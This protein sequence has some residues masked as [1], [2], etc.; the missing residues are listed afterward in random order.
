MYS[1]HG[2]LFLSPVL[3]ALFR[4]YTAAITIG[5]VLTELTCISVKTTFLKSL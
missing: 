2:K 3:S 4:R 5:D 1:I